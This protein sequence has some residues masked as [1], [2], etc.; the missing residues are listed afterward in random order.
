MKSV[1][2]EEIDA[3]VELLESELESKAF[4]QRVGEV[5]IWTSDLRLEERGLKLLD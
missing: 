5:T 4:E 2:E 3:H 1:P